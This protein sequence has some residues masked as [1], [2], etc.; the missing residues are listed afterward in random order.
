M[1]QRVAGETDG[2]ATLAGRDPNPAAQQPSSFV[3]E[4]LG[5]LEDVLAHTGSL[6]A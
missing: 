6:S 3:E 4:T 1:D 5:V 2:D